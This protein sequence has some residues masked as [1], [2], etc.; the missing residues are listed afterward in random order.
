MSPPSD[1]GTVPVV[2]LN[3]WDDDVCA[4]SSSSS[5]H[6]NLMSSLNNTPPSPTRS[7]HPLHR[8]RTSE[9]ASKASHPQIPWKIQRSRAESSDSVRG[10]PLK[11]DSGGFSLSAFNDPTV[12]RPILNLRLSPGPAVDVDGNP[13]ETEH[14][15]KAGSS[16]KEQ[17]VLV[18]EVSSESEDHHVGRV[19]ERPSVLGGYNRLASGSIAQIRHSTGR[20]AKGQSNVAIRFHSSPKVSK[21]SG[22]QG[23]QAETPRR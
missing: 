3:D 18:H 20:P 23:E 21:H 2:S 7:S 17:L 5:H 10:H 19:S 11:R 22:Q 13:F 14:G 1:P 16:E 4:S 6:R 8:R 9:N 15:V 12:T